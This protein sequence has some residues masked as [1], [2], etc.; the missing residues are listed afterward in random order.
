[1][2]SQVTLDA[3]P[4]GENSNTYCITSQAETYLDGHLD[5]SVWKSNEEF[6][7]AALVA[8]AR[9]MDMLVYRGRKYSAMQ[10]LVFPR[11]VHVDSGNPFIPQNVINAQVEQAIFMLRLMVQ[12]G[13]STAR[14]QLIAAGV[15]EARIGDVEEKYGP[16]GRS[17][18]RVSL[19]E[20][21]RGWLRPYTAGMVRW[22]L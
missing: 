18:A 17:Q 12:G 5:E 6:Q 9:Q 19:C 10:A 21:A 14:E 1:M 22:G 16:A 7:E 13:S 20:R 8:A 11:S 2:A 3:T 15:E 4:G